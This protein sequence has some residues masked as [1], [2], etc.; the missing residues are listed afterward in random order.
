MTREGEAEF[1][2]VFTGVSAIGRST[3]FTA[4]GQILDVRSLLAKNGEASPGGALLRLAPGSA[5][6]RRGFLPPATPRAISPMS[7]LGCSVFARQKRRSESGRGATAPRPGQRP[8]APRVSVPAAG[9]CRA[10]RPVVGA[11][12]LVRKL[13]E[14]LSFRVV[15]GAV[16]VWRSLSTTTPPSSFLGRGCMPY[17]GEAEPWG[18]LSRARRMGAV[19]LPFISLLVSAHDVVIRV[20]WQ[21]SNS[22]LICDFGLQRSL[23]PLEQSTSYQSP[24]KSEFILRYLIKVRNIV[25]LLI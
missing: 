1:S 5:Q 14:V 16:C 9:L 10:S 8:E 22:L 4:D 17:R 24:N 20:L 3:N 21:L 15:V 25:L 7:L 13:D 11:V 6:R 2:N 18:H 19:P 23:R 12:W